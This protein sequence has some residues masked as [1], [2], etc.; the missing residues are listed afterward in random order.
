M[1]KQSANRRNKQRQGNSKPLNNGASSPS[2]TPAKPTKIET[3]TT[4]T[5]ATKPVEATTK[6]NGTTPTKSTPMAVKSGSSG[7][8]RPAQPGS[9]TLKRA[10]QRKQQ[11]TQNR[12]EQQRE[13][14]RSTR[15]TLLT[16]ATVVVLVGSL[17]TYLVIRNNAGTDNLAQAQQ[18]VDASYGPVDGVYCSANEQLSYHIHA[19]LSIYINGTAVPLVANTG[20]APIGVTSN[21]NVTCYYWLHTHDTTGVIH[22]ESPTTRLYTLTQFFDIWDKFSST[23]SPFPTQ[24]SSSTGWTIYVNGKQV[25]TDFSHLLLHAHDIVTIA[26]N[27]PGIKPDTTYAWQGL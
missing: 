8:T 25:N 11:K 22:I 7:T 15:A 6:T 26:Y 12:L 9:G 1:S 16:I 14:T 19:H 20:I 13:D 3:K 17:I 5:V 21:A 2:Q 4:G 18:I 10:Q 24:L 27:S 23:A